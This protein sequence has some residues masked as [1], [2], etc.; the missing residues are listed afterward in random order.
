[1][2]IRDRFR[3]LYLDYLKPGNNGYLSIYDLGTRLG[4]RTSNF[5]WN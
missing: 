2:S 1:M 4:T 5:N 3:D